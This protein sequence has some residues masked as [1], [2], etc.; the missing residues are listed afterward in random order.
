MLTKE[1]K[2]IVIAKYARSLLSD[3]YMLK[4]RTFFK[5]IKYVYILFHKSF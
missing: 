1:K 3:G 4:N 5:F 2:S